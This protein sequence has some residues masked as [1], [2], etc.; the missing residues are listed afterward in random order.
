[1]DSETE[2]VPSPSTPTPPPSPAPSTP[3]DSVPSPEPPTPPENVA[4][5]ARRILYDVLLEDYS[6]AGLVDAALPCFMGDDPL[7]GADGWE[8]LLDHILNELDLQVPFPH[9]QG[10]LHDLNAEVGHHGL[11]EEALGHFFDLQCRLGNMPSTAHTYAVSRRAVYDLF[12]VQPQ[13]HNYAL[14]TY[15][16]DYRCASFVINVMHQYHMNMMTPLQNE[17]VWLGLMEAPGDILAHIR[18]GVRAGMIAPNRLVP[19]SMLRDVD[20]TLSDGSD[21]DWV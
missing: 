20:E 8:Q 13:L 21:A 17:A 11:V 15:N 14:T 6:L 1:M 9:V 4:T 3:P 16:M 19:E 18:A 5:A 2:S 7:R 12:G 10:L